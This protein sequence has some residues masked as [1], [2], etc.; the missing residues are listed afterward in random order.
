MFTSTST[1]HTNATSSLKP[2]KYTTYTIKSW[3]MYQLNMPSHL[4]SI[5][6]YNA[7]CEELAKLCNKHVMVLRDEVTKITGYYWC[8]GWSPQ[9][10]ADTDGY[11]DVRSGKKYPHGQSFSHDIK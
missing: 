11:V 6:H 3:Y 7:H 5:E 4:H 9:N 8:T 2:R 10:C 1:C